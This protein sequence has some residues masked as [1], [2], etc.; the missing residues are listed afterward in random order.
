MKPYLYILAV[1]LVGGGIGFYVG[2]KSSSLEHT[3]RPSPKSSGDEHQAIEAILQRQSEAYRLHDPL[4]LLRDCTSTYVEVDATTGESYNLQRAVIRYHAAFRAG[5][6]VVFNVTNR[7][8]TILQRCAIV[9]AQY[10]KTSDQ[11]E[12]EGFKGW[13]GQGIW[14]LSY[15]NGQW[16]I[17]AFAWKEEKKL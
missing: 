7:D 4:L 2:R 1:L 9:R 16:E 15:S 8:I 3:S 11:Y 12:Q 14:L 17:N 5:K 10:A 6:S 13:A